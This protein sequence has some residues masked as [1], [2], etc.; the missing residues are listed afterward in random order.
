MKASPGKQ[1][2]QREDILVASFH[3]RK[4]KK[5]ANDT[6]DYSVLEWIAFNISNLVL[7]DTVFFIL[8]RSL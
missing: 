1:L 6:T 4:S 7:S 3:I 8:S 2:S 5:Y